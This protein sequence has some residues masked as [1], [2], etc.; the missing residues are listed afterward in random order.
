MCSILEMLLFFQRGSKD[1]RSFY[2]T[3]LLNLTMSPVSPTQPLGAVLQQ[4]GLVSAAQVNLALQEQTINQHR[5]GE[6][7]SEHGWIQE[8]TAHFFAETWPTLFHNPDLIPLGQYFRQAHLLTDTQIDYLLEQ[9]YLTQLRFGVLAVAN[10]WVN[11]KT[12][13]FFLTHLH[14]QDNPPLQQSEN[15]QAINFDTPEYWQHLREY[16]LENELANPYS[17]LQL[18]EQ[19]L[20]QYDIPFTGNLEQTAL[21]NL[22]LVTIR[23]NSLEIAHPLFRSVFNP[24]WIQ[25]ERQTLHPYDQIRLQF[26][27]LGKAGAYPYR[28]LEAILTWTNNQP[29]LNQKVAHLVRT[30]SFIQAGEESVVIEQLVQDQIIRNWRTGFANKHL[31]SLE[32]QVL[33]NSNCDLIDLLT[34]YQVVWHQVQTQPTK[35]EEETEL[36]RLGLLIQDSQQVKV[37]NQIYRLVFDQ[38]WLEQQISHILDPLEA[39]D[40]ALAETGPDKIAP[41]TKQDVEFTP[42]APQDRKPWRIVGAFL[43][44]SLGV[45]A[46]IWAL[47]RNPQPPKEQPPAAALQIPASTDR[48]SGLPPSPVPSKTS[49]HQSPLSIASPQPVSKRSP[50]ELTTAN[51]SGGVVLVFANK[52]IPIFSTGVTE[53]D[54]QSAFG[55]PNLKSPGYWPN[56]YGLLYQNIQP[57]HVDFGFLLD[58]DTQRL[59][60]TEA[61]FAPSVAL[62]TLKQTLQGMLKDRPP[63]HI[64]EQLTLIYQR[65]AQDYAFQVGELKG[66]IQR[67]EQDRIYIGVWDA[68]FH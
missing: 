59:R 1:L 10:G 52:K 21:L 2:K 66:I 5:L 29:L 17:L 33:Q 64:T 49:D 26:L 30:G 48:S 43:L 42:P 25:R 22:G 9:Q 65:Q 62:K 58:A 8:P 63:T 46:A 44:G 18:Y 11:L 27:N 51:A 4:A 53:A 37:A 15:D 61:A 34:Y 41:S 12:I 32:E 13:N 3:Q 19:I 39:E 6:L 14:L 56:S 28:I 40:S 20:T 24:E 67:N 23:H 50:A 7:L 55:P 31:S 45:G 36:L 60:Q 54:I 68:D 35:G 47:S 38:T 57:N 16:L